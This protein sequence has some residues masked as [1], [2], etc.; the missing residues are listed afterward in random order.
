LLPLILCERREISQPLLYMS[1]YFEKHYDDYVNHLLTISKHGLWESWIEFFLKGIEDA[2]K[3][4]I[5]RAQALQTLQKTYYEKIQKARSSA[6]LGRLID[7]LF[8]HPA[9]TVP[10]TADRLSITYNAAKN[11]INRLIE[12]QI[13]RSSVGDHHPMVFIATDIVKAVS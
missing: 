1:S 3:D 5:M 11:N 9:I 7:L 12:A 13:L 4:A 10:Y 8:E 6:L 2:C